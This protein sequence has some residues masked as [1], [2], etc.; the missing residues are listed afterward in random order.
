MKNIFT[1]DFESIGFA[2]LIEN[3][4][5]GFAEDN[6]V[7]PLNKI[8]NLLKVNNHTA[9]FFFVGMLSMVSS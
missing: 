3:P 5:L 2:N 7:I 1:I 4:E 6:L 9:T 8:L